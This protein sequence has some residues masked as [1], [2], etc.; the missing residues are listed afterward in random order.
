MREL[1]E[2][3]PGFAFTGADRALDRGRFEGHILVFIAETRLLRGL[4]YLAACLY[5]SNNRPEAIRLWRLVARFDD[6][7]WKTRSLNMLK[8][9]RLENVQNR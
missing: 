3:D 9:P 7:E 6:G 4:Y 8:A 1:R 2:I 5:P